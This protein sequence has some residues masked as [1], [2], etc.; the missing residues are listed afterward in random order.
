MAALEMTN[1]LYAYVVLAVGLLTLFFGLSLQGDLKFPFLAFSSVCVM[2]SMAI[3]KYGYIIIPLLTQFTHVIEVHDAG[4][5]ILPGQEAIVRKI[6]DV[7][8]ASMFLMVRIYESASEKGPEENQVYTQ[9]FER[10]ISSVKYVTKFCTMVYIKDLS[11]Y[12][13]RIETRRAEAQLRLSRERDK[14]DPDILRMDRYE[15]EVAM[16][17]GQLAR[18]AGGVK[19]MGVVSYVMTTATGVTKEA[20]IAASRTQANEL[21]ATI[22]N[23]L[24]TEV[25]LLTGE[26]MKRCFEWEYAIPPSSTELEQSLE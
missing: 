24:N 25:V 26:D 15:R 11:K 19:P 8:Y 1:K 16:Y 22:S 6:G 12:R 3:Y 4:Y 13:E 14:P 23:A 2:L 7:Y 10:A 5:E 20:A 9:Y 18:I 17:D 21:R